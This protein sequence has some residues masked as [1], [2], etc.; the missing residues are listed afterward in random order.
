VATQSQTGGLDYT[1][2]DTGTTSADPAAAQAE[3][4]E[5]YFA[6]SDLDGSFAVDDKIE[7]LDSQISSV[8]NDFWGGEEDFQQELWDELIGDGSSL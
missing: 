6:A 5:D 7:Q 1:V 4:F 2:T 3:T 8:G